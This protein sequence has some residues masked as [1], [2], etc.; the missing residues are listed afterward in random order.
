[1]DCMCG[2]CEECLSDQFL[3]TQEDEEIK[4]EAIEILID[5]FMD[6]SRSISGRKQFLL[7]IGDAT[8]VSERFWELQADSLMH[9]LSGDTFSAL[10]C[11][12]E[13][14]DIVRESYISEQIESVKA[15]IKRLRII[16]ADN[17]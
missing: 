8:L 9:S 16:G 3:E 15:Q 17:E 14:L 7:T 2:G 4:N 6:L 5:R 12:D 11:I 1:M 10:K 13:M